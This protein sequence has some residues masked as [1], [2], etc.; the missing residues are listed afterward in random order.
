[1]AIKNTKQGNTN[2]GLPAKTKNAGLGDQEIVQNEIMAIVEDVKQGKLDKRLDPGKVEGD[3]KVLLQG[4]NELIDA[5]VAPINV[6]AEYIDRISKGD[7]PK[8]ITDTYNG[9]FNEIKNNL[10][11]CI[12]AISGLIVEMNNMSHQH[13][14]GDIDVAIPTEKFQGAY[15]EMGEGVNKMVFGHIAVK[16]KAMAC[17]AEFGNG[18]FDATLETFPGKKVFIN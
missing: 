8:P 6:T 10:N 17:I 16:K 13:D 3:S 7:I 18:N 11:Q 4:I 14:L 1:M 2:S 15:K 5:F 12:E 9:D